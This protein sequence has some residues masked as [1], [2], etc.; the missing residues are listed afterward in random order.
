MKET[1]KDDES[2]NQQVPTRMSAGDA[3][4][5]EEIQRWKEAQISPRRPRVISQRVRSYLMAPLGKVVSFARKVPG[6]EPISRAVSSAALRLMEKTTSV[7]EASVRRRLILKA[8]R[9]AGYD[10]EC[11]EDIRSLGLSLDQI[12]PVRP[13]LKI[14]YSSA[15][16]VEGALSGV[17]A[18]GGS[19]AAVLGLGIASAPGIAL[20]ASVVALDIAT[21]LGAATR[22]VSHTAAYYGYDTVEPAEN[23]FA[24]MVLSQAI[25]P[26]SAGEGAVVEKQTT[27][28]AFNKVMRDVAKRG[29]MGGVGNNVFSAA[30]NSLVASLGARL[31]SLKIAQIV[32]FIGIIVGAF[33]N[34]SL[35][36]TIGDTADHLYRERFLAERYGYIDEAG[37]D[38]AGVVSASLADEI[39]ADIAYYVELTKSEGHSR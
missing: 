8:Y 38:S 16:A 22:L 15:A 12:R 20:T 35:M 4:Q 7:S 5:W 19:V 37:E 2:V 23:F 14:A 3:A 21:F 6:G 9:K 27:M 18:S 33:V 36:R 28:I 30:M 10:V 29:P 1:S 24:T 11:L 13:H 17:I 32:P 31:A 25:D 39:S 26:E 34:A